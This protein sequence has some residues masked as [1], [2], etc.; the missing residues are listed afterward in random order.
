M[1]VPDNSRY[2]L[3]ATCKSRCSNEYQFP[4]S[5]KPLDIVKEF[6][7]IG[8]QIIPREVKNCEAAESNKDVVWEDCEA[9][10]FQGQG[11][12]VRRV[13]EHGRVDVFYFVVGEVEAAD[14]C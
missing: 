9:V 7:K 11:K 3:K 2:I 4:E 14:G 6:L 8:S 10:V 13:G 1:I 5:P 12:Q